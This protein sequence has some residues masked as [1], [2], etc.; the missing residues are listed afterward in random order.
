MTSLTH[1]DSFILGFADMKLIT[2]VGVIFVLFG[3]VVAQNYYE[4]GEEEPEHFFDYIWSTYWTSLSSAT[5]FYTQSFTTVNE[6]WNEP[7]Y[8]SSASIL[9]PVTMGVVCAGL[10]I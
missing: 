10:M 4:D 1:A 5:T 6:Y 8:E 9:L 7:I 2:I 3:L